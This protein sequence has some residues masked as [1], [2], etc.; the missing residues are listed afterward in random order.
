LLGIQSKRRTPHAHTVLEIVRA[1][2]GTL[3]HLVYMVLCLATN[4]IAYVNMALGA[5]ATISTLTG[6]NTV[7]AIFLLPLGVTLYTIT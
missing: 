2:Y 1:R 6:M 5:S 4:I 7:A 3:A